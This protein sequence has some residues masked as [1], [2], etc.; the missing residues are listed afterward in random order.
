MLASGG[1]GTTAGSWRS[2]KVGMSSLAEILNELGGANNP[3][4]SSSE[5]FIL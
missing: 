3:D 5:G 1:P 2:T 4:A